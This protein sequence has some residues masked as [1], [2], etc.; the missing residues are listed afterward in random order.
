VG[1]HQLELGEVQ[2]DPVQVERVLHLRRRG[3]PRDARI[4]RER[5]LELDALGVDRVVERVARREV[6]REGRHP[7]EHDRLPGA[8]GRERA[9]PP[10]AAP[11]VELRAQEEAVGPL[12]REGQ[13]VGGGPL[14]VG[15]EDRL[16]DAELVHQVEGL[17]HR[18]I[19][20]EVLALLEVALRHLLEPGRPPELGHVDVHPAVDHPRRHAASYSVAVSSK[21]CRIQRR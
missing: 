5:E 21:N 1:H 10:H 11:G 14:G 15:G 12:L 18:V 17:G 2:A 8:E 16:L 9:Q 6:D 4:H 20:E 13:H 19:A 3:R 7:G